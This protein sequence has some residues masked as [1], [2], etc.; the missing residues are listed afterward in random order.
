MINVVQVPNVVQV[1]NVVQILNAVRI[2]NAVH[3][4]ALGSLHEILFYI[5]VIRI[6]V[7]LFLMMLPVIA[8]NAVKQTH[9]GPILA[10][11]KSR[12]TG[13]PHAPVTIVEYSDFQC[14]SCAKMQTTVHNLLQTYQGKIRV[15][16]KYYPLIKIHKNAMAAAQAAEC[17]ADQN[18]FWPFEDQLFATQDAWK[19]LQNPTTSYLAIA[20]PLKIDVARFQTCLNDPLKIPIIEHDAA[21]A[22]DRQVTATPT[23]FVGDERLV[24]GVFAT[25]GARAI[26]KELRK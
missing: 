13:D 23:F 2:L 10:T 3:K 25:D 1:L 18:Q 5:T 19:D 22:R 20:L 6:W 21:E 15:M 14:P 12:Q 8:V 16:Y 26:E 4:L 9:W 24:G 11:P 17:A 7:A